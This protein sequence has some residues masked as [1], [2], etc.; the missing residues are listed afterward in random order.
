M[1]ANVYC[2]GLVV[3]L[4]VLLFVWFWASSRWLKSFWQRLGAMASQRG[5]SFEF[6]GDQWVDCKIGSQQ[7]GVPWQLVYKTGHRR[8]QIGGSHIATVV[9]SSSGVALEGGPVVLLARAGGTLPASEED[10]TGANARALEFF[11][12]MLG[13]TSTGMKI[14][15][16]GSTLFQAKY[17]ALSSSVE[18]AHRLV[19]SRVESNLMNWPESP[20][21]VLR[22]PM[23]AADSNGVTITATRPDD[24]FDLSG[25]KSLQAAGE[26]AERML[27]LGSAVIDALRRELDAI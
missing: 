9:W 21:G 3:L 1:T 2:A 24:F 15:P 13:V 23:V 12:R 19:S 10:P 18:G 25:E 7:D 11:L 26:Q 27:A 5:W 8:E 14:Q 17:I 20:T 22:G 16:A 6:I 4:F